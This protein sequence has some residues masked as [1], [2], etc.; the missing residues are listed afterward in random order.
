MWKTL[1]GYTPFGLVSLV[2]GSCGGRISDREITE[3]N[4][5]L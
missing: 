4:L 3:K 2:S 5:G 1:I